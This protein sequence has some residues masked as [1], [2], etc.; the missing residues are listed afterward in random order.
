MSP[1]ILWCVN[2]FAWSA[3][4]RMKRCVVAVG[5]ASKSYSAVPVGASK[6]CVQ[7]EFLQSLSVHS[8]VIAGESIV[9]LAFRKI[10]IN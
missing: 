7:N 10:H 8:F 6:T 3:I 2:T 4:A 1:E 9:S 5:A